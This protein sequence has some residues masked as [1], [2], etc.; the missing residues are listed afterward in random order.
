M[1]II[2]HG[3]R[4]IC[5]QPTLHWALLLPTT[6]NYV[7]MSFY[8][9]ANKELYLCIWEIV[10]VYLRNC[11]CVFEKLYLLLL[12]TTMNYLHLSFITQQIKRARRY[13]CTFDQSQSLHNYAS[14]DIREFACIYSFFIEIWWYFLCWCKTV[15]IL[16]E[17]HFSGNMIKNMYFF[18]NIKGWNFSRRQNR[19]TPKK[20]IKIQASQ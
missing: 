9:S 11:I 4:A 15:N 20:T 18:L 6:M 1:G 19:K 7:R 16:Q 14:N 8:Y 5:Q 17:K 3:W 13:I 10:F 12:P 2:F